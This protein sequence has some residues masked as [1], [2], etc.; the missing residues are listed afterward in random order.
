MGTAA[1]QLAHAA[2]AYVIATAGTDEK[3]AACRALGAALAV[4]Y[5][6]ADFAD[7][8]VTKLGKSCV[9]VVLDMI[10]GEYFRKNL[11]VLRV[12]GR[13]VYIAAMGGH[14]VDLNLLA[15]M[16]KRARLIGSTLRNRPLDEKVALKESFLQQFGDRLTNRSLLP[17]IDS[18]Y[19]LAEAERAHERMLAN[20]NIG[21]IVLTVRGDLE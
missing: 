15:L 9:D 17:V 13:V 21:K 11:D 10:G 14:R 18:E 16:S 7:E 4:N 19:P 6:D 3:C 2:G 12:G 5:R 1:I 20:H 8:I